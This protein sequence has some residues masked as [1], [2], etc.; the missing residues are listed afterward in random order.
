MAGPTDTMSWQAEPAGRTGLP[1]CRT[2][3]AGYRPVTMVRLGQERL[4]E[5][6]SRLDAIAEELADLGRA[7]LT[8]ALDSEDQAPQAEE[9]RLSR[10]RRAVLKAAALLDDDDDNHGQS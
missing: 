4:H 7:K 3:P 8:E 10:A 2:G 5:I 1:S 6:R 9:R